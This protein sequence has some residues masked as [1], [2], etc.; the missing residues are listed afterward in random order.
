MV[1]K[2]R[3][4]SAL[5]IV[6][7]AVDNIL[8]GCKSVEIRSWLPPELPIYDLLLVQNNKYL[9]DGDSDPDGVALA[10]VDIFTVYDWTYNDYL[11]RSN[12]VTLGRKWKKGYYIWELENIRKIEN[13]PKA[14]AQKGIYAINVP[15]LILC[16]S[17]RLS[18]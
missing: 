14:V 11:Q 18:F 6:S 17:Q 5:S 10:L 15:E 16:K 2:M 7:P 9:N 1:M 12:E 4:Y 8:L 13:K 3:E